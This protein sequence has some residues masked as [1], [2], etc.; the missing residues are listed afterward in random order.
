MS[1]RIVDYTLDTITPANPD[2]SLPATVSGCAVIAGPGAT[3][4]GNFPKALDFSA[5]GKLSV[6]LPLASLDKQKFC[7]RTVFKIDTAVVSRQTLVESNAI[8]FAL[9]IAPGSGGSNFHLIAVVKTS[10]F[11]DGKASTEF[12]FDLHLASWY[13]ADLVYDTDTLAVF[14]NGTIY[15][16]HAFP[17][18]TLFN[19]SGDQLFAGTSSDGASNPFKGTLAALQLHADIPIELEAPLDERRAHPQWF[20]TYKQEEIKSTLAFGEPAGEFHYDLPS[21][22]WIQPF[23]GGHIQYHDGN[24]QAF[25]MH[26]AILQAYQALPTRAEI[27]YLVSDETNGAVG[28]SRKSVFSRGGI[29]WSPKTGAIPVLGEIWVDYEG[30][31]E[32]AALGL[33]TAVAIAIPGGTQ[34][35]FQGAQMYLKAS[36]ARAFEVHGAILGKYL[37]TG[38]PGKWGFPVSNEQ[39][40]LS[41]TAPIGRISE[42]EGCSIYWSG[43]SG[44][45]EVHGDIRARYRSVGGA[46]GK[47]GF[48]TSDE[49]DVPGTAGARYNTFQNG[50]ILWFG[51]STETY[52]SFAFDINLGRVDTKESEGWL[53]GENDVYMYATI[54]DN[55]HVIHAERVPASGDSDGHNIVDVSRPFNLGPGGIVTNSPNCIIQ[56]SLDVWDS[57]WPDDDDHLGDYHY[58]LNMANAWGLRGNPNGLFD[59][60]SFDNINSITWSVSP[61]VDEALLSEREKWWGVK[62]IGT[63]Q[64]THEQYAAAFSDVDSDTEWWDPQDWLTSL[65]YS[66]VVG[67]IAKG[68]NCFGMSLAAI[69]SKKDRSFLRLPL[70]RFHDWESIRNEFNIKHQYQ[71]GAPAIWWFVGE[72]LSGKTHDPV[73]VFRATRDAYYSGCDPVLCIAQNYDFSGAPHCILPIGWD[74]SAKPWRMLV[75][76][77]N[78]P[79]LSM[80]DP[81]PRVVYV[82]PDN[83][84]FNYDGGNKYSGGEWT[85][86][87]MHYMPFDL[88][89][90]RPRTPVYEAL[91]L[92]MTGVI[93]ILGSDSET[94]SLT[95]ENGV[96]LDAFGA[97]SVA[98]L[99]A[100]RPLSNKFVSVKG[101]AN[102][103]RDCA[104]ERTRPRPQDPQVPRKPR[105]PGVLTSELHMRSEPK[106]FSRTA[107]PNKRGGS[108]WTRLTLKE[109]LCQLAP[110]EV[111]E[112]FARQA[113]YVAENQGRLVHYLR[114]SATF[115]EILGAVV[116]KLPGGP[117]ALPEISKNFI[118]TTR[119]V[120][121][122]RLQYALKQGLTQMEI[123][124][125]TSAGE[126][127]TVKVSDL[128][129]QTNAITIKGN[130][131][132][133]FRLRVD[134]KLGAGRDYL[135]MT[136]DRV[137]LT[138]GGDLQINVKPGIGG[139][140]LVS[141][142]QEIKAA[143]TLS[144]VRR[145]LELT[146]TFDVNGMDGVRVVPSTVFTA[147]QLKVSRINALFGDSLESKLVTPTV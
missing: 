37:A 129:T 58:T 59:S 32:A 9:Y 48:P 76:D 92:L 104:K 19:S 69:Y 44:A 107:P 113:T 49:Q 120:R 106:R 87:R 14:V 84:A 125:E 4:L 33:P 16:V 27:G 46:A 61:H 22:A 94:L 130:R 71:V 121:G 53:R 112:R 74:D 135:S 8:P 75:H 93:L 147:T 63:D 28:G 25:E 101:F 34:Q 110:A 6:A 99:Q 56:F 23:P 29:Y 126:I 91:M 10:A 11:G 97:D 54:E 38:G 1:Q 78:Y 73:S 123:L 133:L 144:Y 3:T 70:D 2:A 55:G 51:S 117:P 136:I 45:F 21:T 145:G 43:N 124:G 60:G 81:G 57:D 111:R 108:D 146:S 142:G 26:G 13:S 109:Y 64:I 31:G 79:S 105:R 83:N 137:P 36:A 132:K 90:E 118:H 143:V 41:G 127:H 24:G 77:P 18:G 102:H 39:D 80:A 42:F 131:D 103:T 114:S 52:V 96:D 141:A 115:R 20:L 89:N 66:A 95:D 12:F 85:G 122:G 40:V 67:G 72:F 116:N 140:E 128:G 119:G 47:L 50:S 139:I 82:D 100:G 88:V 86:G 65:F 30:M 98:R 68:G 138:A 17:N 5:N 134:N 35:V 15:S 62:N 7:V